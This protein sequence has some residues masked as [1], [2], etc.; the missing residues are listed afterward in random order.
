MVDD[1]SKVTKSS[2]TDIANIRSAKVRTW[3]AVA[4]IY[5]IFLAAYCGRALPSN[6]LSVLALKAGEFLEMNILDI[7]GDKILNSQTDAPADIL[8][9]L[10]STLDICASRTCSL[11]LETVELI[12]PHCI[13]FSLTCLQKLFLLSRHM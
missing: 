1:L 4:D 2:T 10:I 6:A 13:K 12:P 9:R 5:E 11:P 7:L 3:K 8:Q